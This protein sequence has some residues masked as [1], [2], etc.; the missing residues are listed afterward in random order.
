MQ[1]AEFEKFYKQMVDLHRQKMFE[2]EMNFLNSKHEQKRGMWWLCVFHGKLEVR[3]S[4]L[5]GC[6]EAI[7]QRKKTEEHLTY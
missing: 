1:Q 7:Y 4:F 3:L 2:M 5:A 6:F